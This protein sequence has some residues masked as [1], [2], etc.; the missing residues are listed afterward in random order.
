MD[1]EFTLLNRQ[2]LTP[3]R[4]SS[5]SS[6]VS[7]GNQARANERVSDELSPL[8]ISMDQGDTFART[9]GLPPLANPAAPRAASPGAHATRLLTAAAIGLGGLGAMLATTSHC[10]IKPTLPHLAGLLIGLELLKLPEDL[11]DGGYGHLVAWTARQ[12]GSGVFA[13]LG[14][15]AFFGLSPQALGVAAA[16]SLGILVT[17]LIATR[18]MGRQNFAH[19]Q[20]LSTSEPV[21]RSIVYQ[22]IAVAGLAAVYLGGN[23]LKLSPVV[24]NSSAIAVFAIQMAKGGANMLLESGAH[25]TWPEKNISFSKRLDSSEKAAE[26][27]RDCFTSVFQSVSFE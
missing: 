23:L 11:R 9:N 14:S 13:V 4:S 7:L 19:V 21:K 17:S 20:E 18:A 22:D 12:A 5:N 25:L 1:N 10:P 15:A 8:P 6:L 26:S 24:K 27:F 16:V 2:S 3:Q